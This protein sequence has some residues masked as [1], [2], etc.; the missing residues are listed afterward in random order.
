MKTLESKVALVTGS[1][2]GIGKSIAIL[3]AENGAK[4]VVTD[5]NEANGNAVVKEITD[6]GGEAVFIKSDSSK[7]EDNEAAVN[8]AIEAFGKL[9]IAVNNAGIGGAS[10]PVGEYPIDSWNKVIAVNLNGVFYGLH[11]QIPAIE[12]TSGGKGSIINMASILG[13]VGFA[14]S[15][16][17]VAA[18]HGVVG[19]T[20]NAAVEYATR[21]VRVNA[22]GP[23]FIRTPLLASMNKDDYDAL[24]AK[25][26]MKRLGEAEEVAE[27]CLWLASDKASFVT[28]SYYAVD[29]GY[30]S[31]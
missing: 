1:G 8:K 26:P 13:Q 18:K 23:A 4:I 24:A 21:G 20:K 31:V 16:A 10:V 17:Y 27:L 11:Y 3:F 2:S 9:D 12:K 25:H 19:L 30:L 7:P 6:Q 5:V 22:V 14:N 28:G 15:S 29:G